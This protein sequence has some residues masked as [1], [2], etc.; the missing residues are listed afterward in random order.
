LSGQKFSADYLNIPYQNICTLCTV[1][2]GQ[3]VMLTFST[4][5]YYHRSDDCEWKQQVSAVADLLK[6]FI[7]MERDAK[8]S[9]QK[10]HLAGTPKLTAKHKHKQTEGRGTGEFLRFIYF[11]FFS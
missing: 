1:A 10:P 11:S 5:S 7:N 2:L 9:N 4:F 6:K 8:K 3:Q